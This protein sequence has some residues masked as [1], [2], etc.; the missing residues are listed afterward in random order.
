MAG[1]I[2]TVCRY[3]VLCAG[4]PSCPQTYCEHTLVQW[5][6]QYRRP[7]MMLHMPKHR[8]IWQSARAPVLGCNNNSRCCSAHEQELACPDTRRVIM[9]AQHSSTG[10]LW[11]CRPTA[12][13]SVEDALAGEE[14]VQQGRLQKLQAMP[15]HGK[16]LAAAVLLLSIV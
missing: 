3:G 8:A 13:A 5:L 6:S 14:L 9:L 2:T 10:V 16:H 7:S 1:K 11:V 4:S 12:V 15:Q